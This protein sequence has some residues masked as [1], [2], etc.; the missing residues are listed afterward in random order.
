[1]EVKHKGTQ[2]TCLLFLFFVTH[3]STN[4]SEFC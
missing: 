1:L 2:E 4:H 3:K